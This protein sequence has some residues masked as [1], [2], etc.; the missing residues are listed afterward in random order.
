M[1]PF[2]KCWS[3]VRTT[4]P[5]PHALESRSYVLQLRCFCINCT[6][7][8]TPTVQRQ[9]A[10]P[11][12]ALI[13]SKLRQSVVEQLLQCGDMAADASK[14]WSDQ[15]P[16]LVLRSDRVVLKHIIATTCSSIVNLCVRFRFRCKYRQG[17]IRLQIYPQL[18]CSNL[19]HVG[20]GQLISWE[21]N[22]FFHQLCETLHSLANAALIDQL[23]S[24]LYRFWDGILIVVNTIAH[25]KSCKKAMLCIAINTRTWC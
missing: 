17:K 21:A 16:Q 15:G 25:A 7:L 2:S 18:T 23:T 22:Y 10:K 11:I 24:Y 8:L 6:N 9:L 13:T 4:M 12:F 20:H 14:P 3:Q 5:I 1:N 19:C